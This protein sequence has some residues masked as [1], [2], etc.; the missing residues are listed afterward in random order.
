MPEFG[1][2]G[3]VMDQTLESP[4]AE[5]GALPAD[6]DATADLDLQGLADSQ[7]DETRLSDTLQ[8]ALTLLEKD[9]ENE[10][11]ASQI[12]DQSA[13]KQALEEEEDF[14][15]APQKRAG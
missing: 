10:L 2:S 4:T 9:F 15:P 12:I 14:D 6:T 3:A 13:I 8:E 1:Q 7:G 11:T 5:L